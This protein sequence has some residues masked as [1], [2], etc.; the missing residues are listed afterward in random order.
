MFTLSK[1]IDLFGTPGK[2]ARILNVNPATISRWPEELTIS[3]CD[4]IVGAAIRVKGIE[5]TRVYFPMYFEG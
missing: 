5:K 3:Q 1:A 4:E 2:M